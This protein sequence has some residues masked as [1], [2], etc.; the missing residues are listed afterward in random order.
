MLFLL[1]LGACLLVL[2]RLPVKLQGLPRGEVLSAS[3][4]RVP[5][6]LFRVSQEEVGGGGA[7][8]QGSIRA[9]RAGL[10]LLE[11]KIFSILFQKA[12]AHKYYTYCN[13]N[14]SNR[15]SK[16]LAYERWIK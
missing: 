2:L 9:V 7:G 4:A 8:R 12:P 6:S 1:L 15:T 3:E 16:L 11:K 10:P 5:C 14:K 13:F